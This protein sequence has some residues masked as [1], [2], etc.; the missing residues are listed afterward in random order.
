MSNVVDT[1][2]LP[3]TID[4]IDD[5]IV[6]KVLR[7]ASS[8]KLYRIT[9]QELIFYKKQKIPLPRKH[10]DVRYY[11]RLARRPARNLYLRKCDKCGKEMVSVYKSEEITEMKRSEEKKQLV[12]CEQCYRKEIYG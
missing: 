11:E 1:K 6:H 10:P 4:A 8:G 2:D 3:D 5:D 12:Y 7:C 9:Q